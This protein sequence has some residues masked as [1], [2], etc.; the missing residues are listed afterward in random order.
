MGKALEYASL[1]QKSYTHRTRLMTH[2]ITDEANFSRKDALRK[3]R[4]K[5]HS[6]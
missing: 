2:A 1:R 3:H 6:Y 5:M 4:F